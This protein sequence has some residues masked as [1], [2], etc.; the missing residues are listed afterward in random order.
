MLLSQKEEQGPK[1]QKSKLMIR[2][3]RHNRDACA[4]RPLAADDFGKKLLLFF[5][6]DGQKG[7]TASEVVEQIA[8]K[9]DIRGETDAAIEHY[10]E[11]EFDAE[12]LDL[13]DKIEGIVQ[14][15]VESRVESAAEEAA[16]QAI[17]RHER[18]NDHLDGSEYVSNDDLDE[19]IEEALEE[20]S[21]KRSAELQDALDQAIDRH[22]RDNDHLNGSEFVDLDEKIEEALEEYSRKR[23]AEPD[24]DRRLAD[25]VQ[26]VVTENLDTRE[27]RQVIATVVRASVISEM[28][29][30]EQNQEQE[31]AREIQRA[32]NKAVEEALVQNPLTQALKRKVSGALVKLAS[33]L[34]GLAS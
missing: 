28:N 13:D 14:D 7:A 11:N 4:V 15:A 26:T 33:K 8:E 34:E 22:E 12:S 31:R 10:M 23:S 19:K 24:L 1:T 21:R 20:Y 32:A 29:Q 16:D 30:R 5:S 27:L 3:R 6:H 17:D 25:M 18:D 2:L 9:L